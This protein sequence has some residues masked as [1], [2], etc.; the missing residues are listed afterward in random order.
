MKKDRK[1]DEKSQ[2]FLSFNIMAKERKVSDYILYLALR[3]S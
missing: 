3:L 1:E 2:K